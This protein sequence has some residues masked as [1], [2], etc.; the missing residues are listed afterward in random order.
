MYQVKVLS[1]REPLTENVD[2][3]FWVNSVYNMG[4]VSL[5]HKEVQI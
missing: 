3:L 4:I 5:S 2:T 1:T